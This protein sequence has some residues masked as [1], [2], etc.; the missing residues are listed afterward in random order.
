MVLQGAQ[1]TLKTPGCIVLFEAE[2]PHAARF[3]Y[4]TVD[5]KR[6]MASL[7]YRLYRARMAG[8]APQLTEVDLA[9]PEDGDMIVGLAAA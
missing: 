9:S 2:E 8:R 3:G 5:L 6:Y 1:E 7:G 4:S